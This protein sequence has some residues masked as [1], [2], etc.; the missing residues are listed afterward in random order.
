MTINYEDGPITTL[1]IPS[2]LDAE[3]GTEIPEDR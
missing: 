1:A 2:K 3:Q